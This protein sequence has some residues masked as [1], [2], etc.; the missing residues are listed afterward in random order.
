MIN[1]KLLGPIWETVVLQF[2]ER[3]NL[4]SKQQVKEKKKNQFLI[5]KINLI[6]LSAQQHY[7]N[8]PYQLGTGSGDSAAD[9]GLSKTKV[10]K[11]DIVVMATD[12]LWDNLFIEEIEKMIVENQ[13]ESNSIH[14]LCNNLAKKAALYGERMD[15]YS[16]FSKESNNTFMGGKLDDVAVIVGIVCEGEIV[17]KSNL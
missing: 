8:C 4:F 2:S 10:E 3:E 11:D 1:K 7:F 6:F 17:F 16:P 12:G 13:K 14:A 9:A 15:Y 5:L